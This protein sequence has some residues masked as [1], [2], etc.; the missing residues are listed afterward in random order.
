M[1]KQVIFSTGLYWNDDLLLCACSVEIFFDEFA[2]KV[3]VSEDS[4]RCSEEDN[5]K[6]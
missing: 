4:Y 6:D 5:R 2:D 1:G 3:F